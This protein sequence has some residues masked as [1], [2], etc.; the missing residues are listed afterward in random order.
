MQHLTYAGSL[1]I[2]G[3]RGSNDDA[4]ARYRFRLP[5]SPNRKGVRLYE[6]YGRKERRRKARLCIKPP[7]V[8]LPQQ[9][10]LT[11]LGKP[12]MAAPVHGV[13]FESVVFLGGGGAA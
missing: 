9:K 13:R 6:L 4:F 2:L 1:Q 12:L 10:L 3:F 11:A 7:Q 5:I 8:S